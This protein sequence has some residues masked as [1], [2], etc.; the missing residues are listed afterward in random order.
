MNNTVLLAAILVGVGFVTTVRAQDWPQWGGPARDSRSAET[1]LLQRWP[2]A[3]PQLL[4]SATGLGKG[5]A[6]PSIAGDTVYVM[7]LV[8]DEEVLF[9]LGLDGKPKWSR[10]CGAGWTRANAGARCQPA[11]VGGRVY[12]I[13][14]MLQVSCLDAADGRTIW[15]VDAMARFTGTNRSYGN[16]ESPLVVD[17]KV[18]VS[19]GGPDASIVALDAATGETVWTTRGLSQPAC[20]CSPILVERGGPRIITMLKEGLVGVDARDGTILWQAQHHNKYDNHMNSPVYGDGLLFITSGYGAGGQMF[21]LAD[22]GKAITKLWQ[23]PKPDTM[24]GGVVMHDGHI[25]GSSNTKTGGGGDWICLDAATGTVVYQR[26]WVKAGAAVYADGHLYCYGED[27]IVAL[28]PARP[29][30]EAATSQFH[31]TL[32]SGPHGAHPVVCGKRLYLR[33]GEVLLAYSLAE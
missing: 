28:V 24:H 5:W 25:Y 33:H 15:R 16:A 3:G 26:R 21:R 7:G 4:W 17:G 6:S 27:G 2:D 31:V 20:Y 8:G 30:C 11:V 29:D 32:G 9:A 22:D 13:S 18:I 1:G 10:P 23:G 19:P 12:V 14:S